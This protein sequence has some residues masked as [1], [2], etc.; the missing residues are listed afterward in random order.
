MYLRDPL[1]CFPP[2]AFKLTCGAT[3]LFPKP[4][5]ATP[6]SFLLGRLGLRVAVFVLV[7]RHDNIPEEDESFNNNTSRSL[8]L[9]CAANNSL[10]RTVVYVPVCGTG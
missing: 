2:K 7:V 10:P 8:A 6:Q 4:V 1:L 3:G 9:D 5:G